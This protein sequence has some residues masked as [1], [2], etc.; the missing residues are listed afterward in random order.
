MM[1]E[2]MVGTTAET[3][4]ATRVDCLAVKWVVM[5]AVELDAGKAEKK[6]EKLVHHLVLLTVV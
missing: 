6:A 5:K 1:A 4:V 2:L 3:L